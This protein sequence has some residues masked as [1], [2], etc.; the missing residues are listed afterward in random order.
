[1]NKKKQ[2][3]FFDW[4]DA[5]GDGVATRSPAE[6]V[7]IEAALCAPGIVLLLTLTAYEACITAPIHFHGDKFTQMQTP[8]RTRNR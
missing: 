2:K 7:V 1:V 5:W 6:K 3:N 8:I 4:D